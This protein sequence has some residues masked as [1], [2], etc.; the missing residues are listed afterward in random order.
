MVV[1]MEM[2]DPP[3]NSNSCDVN[4]C[5]RIQ[6]DVV[7]SNSGNNAAVTEKGN[8][9][10]KDMPAT[11]PVTQSNPVVEQTVETVPV[12]Q[13]VSAV[14]DNVNVVPEASEVTNIIPDSIQNDTEIVVLSSEPV[15]TNE[16]DVQ[17]VEVSNPVPQVAVPPSGAVMQPQV[18]VA[19]ETPQVAQAVL[20][21]VVDNNSEFSTPNQVVMPS[22]TSGVVP[23]TGVVDSGVSLANIAPSVPVETTNV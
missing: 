20:A 10:A 13:E 6:G 15:T 17:P 5:W 19:Q 1:K 11:A 9:T 14:N 18:N 4:N 12:N 2:P 16:T 3:P 21:P 22:N 7:A 23:P 8:P